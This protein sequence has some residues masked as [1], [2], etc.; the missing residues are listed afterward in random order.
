MRLFQDKPRTA[1][2]PAGYAE[3]LFEYL[4]R[5][6]RQVMAALRVLFESWFEQHPGEHQPNLRGRLFS[7]RKQEQVSAWWELY[8]HESFV[9]AGYRVEV[10]AATRDFTIEGSGGRFHVEATARFESEAD[11]KLEAQQLMLHD[12]LDGLDAAPWRIGV[13]LLSSGERAPRV[14]RFKQEISSWLGTLD[15][16]TVFR[17]GPQRSRNGIPRYPC[18]SFSDGGWVLDVEAVPIGTTGD[19]RGRPRAICRW[20]KGEMVRVQNER[21]I[22]DTIA[23]K[24]D[25]CR[26][27]DAPLII[28]VLLERNYGHDHQV[29]TALFGVESTECVYDPARNT[30][31]DGR[32]FRAPGGFWSPG[33]GDCE[34]AAVLSGVRLDCFSFPQVAPVMWTNP[35]RHQAPNRTGCGAALAAPLVGRC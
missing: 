11:R 2:D 20:G 16:E 33:T 28:A 6:G 4:D 31:D 7:R 9:R 23:G 13:E 34:V 22:Y 18:A 21:P 10:S 15:F 35:L 26:G 14:R 8:L 17:E 24:A 27:L 30:L 25:K 1:R 29:E 5:S 19:D 32:R 12:L 3:T